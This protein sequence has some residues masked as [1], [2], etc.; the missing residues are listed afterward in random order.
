[1]M[2]SIVSFQNNLQEWWKDISDRLRSTALHMNIASKA[3]WKNNDRPLLME[4]KLF[5]QPG[6]SVTIQM[7]IHVINRYGISD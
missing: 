1:M 7:L 4:Q 6:N 5:L 3:T 2:L